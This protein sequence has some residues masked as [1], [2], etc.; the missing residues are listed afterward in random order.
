V[1]LTD[2]AD[3]GGNAWAGG[4]GYFVTTICPDMSSWPLP[5]KMLQ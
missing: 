4:F 5:Q 3:S 1:R 2:F